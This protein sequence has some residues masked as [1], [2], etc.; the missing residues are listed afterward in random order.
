MIDPSF[1]RSFSS[2]SACTSTASPTC[3]ASPTFSGLLCPPVSTKHW[4]NKTST[5]TRFRCCRYRSPRPGADKDGDDR[6]DHKR[7][8]TA[9][10]DSCQA[11]D[12]RRTDQDRQGR[13]PNVPACR[14]SHEGF[15]AADR[16]KK[17]RTAL[18]MAD[19]KPRG[20]RSLRHLLEVVGGLRREN[21]DHFDAAGES[22]RLHRSANS[23]YF[24][25][26]CR[27]R[28]AP[29]GRTESSNS[30]SSCAESGAKTA[31]NVNGSPPWSCSG[32]LTP[33]CNEG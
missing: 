10:P 9:G 30:S 19:M 27:K 11:R 16:G 23:R 7:L 8:R 17:A 18:P 6:S 12:R 33:D 5:S 28:P 14:S 29:A 31:S 22:N 3:T 32:Q 21:R 20:Y 24:S 13:A 15:S 1:I 25:P 2:A 4:P 26:V